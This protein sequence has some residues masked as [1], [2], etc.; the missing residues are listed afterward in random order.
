MSMRFCKR[1]V[2]DAVECRLIDGEQRLLLAL[3]A[4]EDDLRYWRVGVE[5]WRE[6]Y[7]ARFERLVAQADDLTSC[8]LEEVASESENAELA[9][10]FLKILAA[11]LDCLRA[12][13][14]EQHEPLRQAI[15][16]RLIHQ[17]RD[18]NLH[19]EEDTRSFIL[20]NRPHSLPV[21]L[22]KEDW[23]DGRALEWW[24]Y[25]RLGL[26]DKYATSP[27][28]IAIVLANLDLLAA[29][30]R[31]GQGASNAHRLHQA[32]AA[33]LTALLYF[34]EETRHEKL[35]AF[36]HKTL[37]QIC[38]LLIQNEA[39]EIEEQK[40][41][42]EYLLHYRGLDA[43]EQ[44]LALGAVIYELKALTNENQKLKPRLDAAAGEI[45]Q[46]YLERYQIDKALALWQFVGNSHDPLL[47]AI[48][49]FYRHSKVYALIGIAL[50][51]LTLIAPPQHGNTWALLS[52]LLA[53]SMMASATLI[54]L[55]G[56]GLTLWR[57]I[58]KQGLAYIDLFFPRLFG[59]IVVGI[60]ILVFESTVW[61]AT[62]NLHWGNWLLLCLASYV[63]S[64]LYFF[65]DVHKTIRLLPL[66]TTPGADAKPASRFSKPAERSLRATWQVFWIGFSEALITSLLVSG[67]WALAM[68]PQR[69]QKMLVPLIWGNV[70]LLIGP[71]GLPGYLWQGR[72]IAFAFLPKIVLLWAGLSLLIGAFAQ[73]L[74]Q[75]H[76]ITSM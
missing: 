50:M 73:L 53:S 51:A 44:D 1:F 30:I 25:W 67:F 22:P 15:E 62:L 11:L 52:T 63:G 45:T 56:G 33:F 3:R 14:D 74:W 38:V 6:R 55:S 17:N 40:R 19:I 5:R 75:D 54:T 32:Y 71:A 47:R 9:V 57:L 72:N 39:I 28:A 48:L 76:Q 34:L 20:D 26:E 61:E 7:P 43:E 42:L 49:T 58:R 46:F 35:V 65:V 21:K 41:Y 29:L 23:D 70:R 64:F 27:D 4:P 59:A 68:I 2:E 60:S 69:I 12:H 13:P 16:Q 36:R 18:F 66:A 31:Y 10:T 8:R 37:P 24:R